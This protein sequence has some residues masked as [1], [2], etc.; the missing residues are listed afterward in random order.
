[1]LTDL[2]L[3]LGV[4]TLALLSPGPDFMIVVKNS[5]GGDRALA[6]GTVGGI[7]TGLAVQML[8]IG[9]G[10]AVLSPAAV[11][12]VQLGGAL[13]LGWV[14]VRAVTSRERAPA[15]GG[16]GAE[17]RG[18]PAGRW[19]GAGLRTGFWQGLGCNVLNPKA[20]LFFVS[21]LAQVLPRHEAAAWRFGV[22]VAIVVHG[23]MCWTLIVLALQSRVV[24]R[25]LGR[26][27]RWLPR[28][29]GGVL[30]VLA[31]LLLVVGIAALRVS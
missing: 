4:L 5:I 26:A 17:N 10:L 13:F 22:P 14:G 3:V 19:L 9:S 24:A 29:F 30:A 25:R 6:L 15:M 12:G 27:Q 18:V 21:L 2:A 1:M 31:A 8:V 7:G 11:A 20:F 23:V 16:R 28:A